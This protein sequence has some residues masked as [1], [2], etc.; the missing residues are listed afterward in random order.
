MIGFE[1][2]SELVDF[3]FRKAKQA[4]SVYS[5]P[6]AHYEIIEL[7]DLPASKT[8]KIQEVLGE[9]TGASTVPR[10][11]INGV[12]LGG[13]DDTVKALR[14]GELATLLKEAGAI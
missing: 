4:L 11:F 12:C 13:G 10:V 6:A 9:L 5:I 7:D 3:N 14:N 2:I 8:E 1:I